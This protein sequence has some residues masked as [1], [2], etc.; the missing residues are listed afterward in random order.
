MAQA[1]IRRPPS[2]L[3]SFAGGIVLCKVALG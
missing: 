2:G 3:Y 1:V